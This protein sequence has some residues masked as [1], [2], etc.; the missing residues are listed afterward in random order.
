MASFVYNEFKGEVM[1]GT[2][3]LEADTVYAALMATGHSASTADDNGWSSVSANEASG[4]GYVAN[5][6]A[7][8]TK[9]VSIDDTDDEG[10]FDADDAQWTSSTI[11][12][13]YC[14]VWDTTPTVP[15]DPL[16][17][18]IDF[19]GAQSS[20]SGTFTIQWAGEGILNI[21]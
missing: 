1:N 2:F 18:S 9:A 13:Y 15:A 14:V 6:D 12:A 7:L 4:T 10:V 20:S 3:D 19:G 11:T 8:S 5:G 21:G 17:C 16:V